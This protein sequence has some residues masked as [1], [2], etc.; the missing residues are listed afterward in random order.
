[1]SMKPASFGLILEVTVIEILTAAKERPQSRGHFYILCMHE[2]CLHR[3]QPPKLIDYL[4]DSSSASNKPSIV[5][6]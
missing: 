6:C 4:N 3:K 5:D 2:D 1:L